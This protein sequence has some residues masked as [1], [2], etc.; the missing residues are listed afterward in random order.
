MTSA[1]GRLQAIRRRIADAARRAG[2]QPEQVRLIAVS[3]TQSVAA[4]Q[5]LVGLGVH[6]FGES[7]VREGL[8]K[9]EHFRDAALNWHFVG[10]LQSNKTRHMAGWF[11]WV[12]SV[13]SARLARR[14]AQPLPAGQTP[15]RLLL[16]VNVAQDPAKHGLLPHEVYPTVEDLLQEQ[17]PGIEFRGLMTIGFLGANE[18]QTRASFAALRDLLEGCRQRFGDGFSELSM[19]MSDDFEVAVEEGATMVR[20]GTALFGGRQ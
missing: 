15:L 13:D 4:I 5:S 11:Q 19:G 20:V 3:K 12:H 2:R 14:L 16:Q 7:Q 6:D 10:H 18:Y 17:L 1:A 9:I 8:Q